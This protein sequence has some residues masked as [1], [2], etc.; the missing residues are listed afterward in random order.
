MNQPASLIAFGVS[1]HQGA[2]HIPVSLIATGTKNAGHSKERAGEVR[3]M[4]SGTAIDM[5][6]QEIMSTRNQQLC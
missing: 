3:T 2:G 4:D 1:F 6:A 5:E